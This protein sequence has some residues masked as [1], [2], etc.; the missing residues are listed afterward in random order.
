MNQHAPGRRYSRAVTAL[1][2]G[3]SSTVATATVVTVLVLGGRATFGPTSAVVPTLPRPTTSP[4][5]TTASPPVT[6]PP[7]P[8]APPSASPTVAPA[9]AP[10]TTISAPAAPP[11]TPSPPPKPPTPTLT[12]TPTPTIRPPISVRPEPIPVFPVSP[13]TRKST[14]PRHTASSRRNGFGSNEDGPQVTPASRPC[15]DRGSCFEWHYRG[16]HWRAL[17]AIGHVRQHQ[18]A[19]AR[20]ESRSRIRRPLTPPPSRRGS[21]TPSCR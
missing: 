6:S 4:P 13:K 1:T 16:L 20:A 15:H 12:H 19:P 10:P 9:P 2:V 3:V 8:P 14:E 11:S 18:R 21:T 7:P 17:P 5:T